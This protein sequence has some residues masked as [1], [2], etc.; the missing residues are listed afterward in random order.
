MKTATNLSK[1]GE[2]IALRAKEIADSVMECQGR[3]DNSIDGRYA[4]EEI[5]V[6]RRDTLHH[7]QHLSTALR[8]SSRI[9]F[10]SYVEWLKVLMNSMGVSTED[11][12]TNQV[13]IE[14]AI[15][16][17]IHP[18][19]ADPVRDYLAAGLLRLQEEGDG[20]VTH[21]GENIEMSLL[22]TQYLNALLNGQVETAMKL[23]VEAAK[24]GTD[25]KTLYLDVFA[26]AQYEVG[27][28]W[29]TGEVSV[30]QEHF[31]T[32]ATQLVMSQLYP[33]ISRTERKGKR[34]FLACVQGELHDMGIR[35]LRDFF[36]MD[37]WDTVF[38][39][40]NTPRQSI[41]TMIEKTRPDIVAISVTMTHNL[42]E[43]NEV[44]GL[45]RSTEE[46]KNVRI[47]VGGN[48]F[49]VDPDLWKTVGADGQATDAE[50]ALATASELIRS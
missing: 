32:A 47:M 27:R 35:I 26:S 4:E 12:I 7:L 14:E 40:C 25:L 20:V 44:I 3:K 1:T 34:V 13:C 21:F 10:E 5:R 33:F 22:A 9:L 45:I 43:L 11:L 36:L 2:A 19:P 48:P 31:C 18:D 37:G 6:C 15:E 29:L 42:Q 16:D 41:V 30:A 24:A 28:L 39:G 38:L 50:S 23:V 8:F 49:M 46:T 17:V